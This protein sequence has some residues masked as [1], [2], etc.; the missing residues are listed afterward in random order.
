MHQMKNAF[1]EYISSDHAGFQM[2]ESVKNHL[3][4]KMFQLLIWV[5][6]K[7]N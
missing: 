5:P 7:K 1:K 6:M 4:Q 3:I 2:K